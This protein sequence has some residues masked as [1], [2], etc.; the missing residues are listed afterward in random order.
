MSYAGH[1]RLLF[2]VNGGTPLETACIV[3]WTPHGNTNSALSYAD[4]NAEQPPDT[5]TYT[6]KTK[7]RMD[8]IPFLTPEFCCG[9][10]NTWRYYPFKFLMSCSCVFSSPQKSCTKSCQS[11]VMW[12]PQALSPSLVPQFSPLVFVIWHCDLFTFLLVF[13]LEEDLLTH[14][15]GGKRLEAAGGQW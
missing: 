7:S 9:A 3:E 5:S 13:L 4:K 11:L 14:W 1:S 10:N 12:L 15:G 2:V 6:R 8:F